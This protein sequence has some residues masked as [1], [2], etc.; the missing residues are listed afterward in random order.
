[1]VSVI[2]IA[3]YAGIG[4]LSY[5]IFI[6]CPL[7][8][9]INKQAILNSMYSVVYAM[10]YVQIKVTKLIKIIKE[11]DLVRGFIE[12]SDSNCNN[13]IETVRD[14]Y[15]NFVTTSKC[16]NKQCFGLPYDFLIISYIN[17]SPSKIYKKLLKEFDETQEKHFEVS[18]VKFILIEVIIGDRSFKLDL[19]S[20]TFNYYVVNNI[21][22]NLV[23]T[24]LMRTQYC[25]E[26]K[27]NRN[28]VFTYKLRIID[29]NV[30]TVEIVSDKSIKL[31]K[32]SYE[33]I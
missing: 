6:K 9:E 3:K 16:A 8:G 20:D 12:M 21:I 14:G 15:V 1:M 11:H 33:I 31:L 7:I 30:D 23:V 25:Y 32:D 22:D 10:S 13:K 18:N 5:L 4:Y 2:N 27:S 26:M 24:Y 29:N 19:T 28:D 17:H